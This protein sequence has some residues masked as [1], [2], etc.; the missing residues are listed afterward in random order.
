M[1]TT[2]PRHERPTFLTK[3]VLFACVALVAAASLLGGPVSFA[4]WNDQVAQPAQL[5]DSASAISLDA[6]VTSSAYALGSLSST[7]ATSSSGI[8]P[9]TRGQKLTF[10]M[11]GGAGNGVQGYISG[12]VAASPKSAW[13]AVYTAGYLTATATSTGACTVNP[14]P[15]VV[16]GALT[17]TFSTTTGQTV[18]AGQSCTVVLDLSIPAVKNGVDVSRVLRGTRGTTTVLNPFADFTANATLSQVPRAE[19]KP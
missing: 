14:A 3:P 15:V 11:T 12:T 2:E 16:S 4:L 10:A 13:A 9:G 7:V 1:T 18:K 8:I 19:E 5:I 6:S 17:W